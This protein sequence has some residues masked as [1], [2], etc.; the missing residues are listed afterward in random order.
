MK[1]I[2]F[3]TFGGKVLRVEPRAILP[4]FSLS[5]FLIYVC[6]YVYVFEAASLYVAQAVLELPV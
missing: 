5:Y 2:L 6:I 1:L 3:T 4:A